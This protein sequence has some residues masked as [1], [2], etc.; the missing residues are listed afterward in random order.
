MCSQEAVSAWLAVSAATRALRILEAA[1]WLVCSKLLLLY[2]KHQ[3][4]GCVGE[5]VVLLAVLWIKIGVNR[6][7]QPLESSDAEHICISGY[8]YIE[9]YQCYIITHHA[10]N[11]SK[12]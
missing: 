8:K 10:Q 6:Y 4:T 12:K 11:Y 2:P 1:A 7:D 3:E 9:V 5:V